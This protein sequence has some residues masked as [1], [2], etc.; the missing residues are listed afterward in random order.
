MNSEICL[1]GLLAAPEMLAAL[2]LEA[3]NDASSVT[4]T[5]VGGARAGIDRDGWPVLAPSSTRLDLVRVTANAALKRY[6][7]VMG[8]SEIVWQG[9]RVLG[10]SAAGPGR[11]T[12][13]TGEPSAELAALIANEILEARAETCAEE[14][15]AR[16]PMISVWADSR[17]RAASGPVSGG[18]IVSRRE[19]GDIRIAQRE[20][21]FS[22][23][24]G[25]EKQVLSHRTHDGGFTPSMTREAFVMGDAVVVLPWDPVRD[26]VL[27][28]E[29]FR[30]APAVRHDPQP[31]LLEPIAGRIDAGES[32]EQAARREALEEADLDLGQM[33][34]AMHHYPSPGA[35]GEFLYMYVGIADLP[36]GVAGVHGL[37]GEVEDIRGHLMESDALLRMVLANEI[38]NG[39][40]AGLALWLHLKKAELRRELAPS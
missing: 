13:A 34:A 33:F 20:Q 11:T 5:L 1:V 22:G 6:A 37:D 19:P 38:T 10:A 3:I 39:P 24:F 40:L 29:Q 18:G 27:V 16:L 15:A 32:V 4:G 36:D 8:I 31:W 9:Q 25:V 2:G 14:I 26:R 21:V 28:I 35:V 7:E 17:R 12:G 30:F 23:F